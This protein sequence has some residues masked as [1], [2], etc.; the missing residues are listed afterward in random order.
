MLDFI[1]H[2]KFKLILKNHIFD[3]KPLRFCH[4]LRNIVMDVIM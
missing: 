3:M 1:Y 4:L 2:M